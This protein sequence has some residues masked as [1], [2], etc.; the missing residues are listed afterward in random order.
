MDSR[1]FAC[2]DSE[3]LFSGKHFLP[4]NN[5]GDTHRFDAH[6][7]HNFLQ[8]LANMLDSEVVRNNNLL[9]HQLYVF[10]FN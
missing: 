5:F 8:I 4:S 10:P 7:R 9:W 3:L 2:V 1:Q 6:L